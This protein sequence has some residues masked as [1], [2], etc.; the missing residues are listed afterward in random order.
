MV[1][2][3]SLALLATNSYCMYAYWN[4]DPD[5][6]GFFVIYNLQAYIFAR[7][8]NY[9]LLFDEDVS[10]RI[11]SPHRSFRP[12]YPNGSKPVAMNTGG[13]VGG[14]GGEERLMQELERQF[15]EDTAEFE[16][17]P[18]AATARGGGGGSGG[19]EAPRTLWKIVSK[20]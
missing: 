1:S 2:C 5:Y 14:L 17:S 11:N 12:F 4:W 18:S 8:V 7:C 19:S 3:R 10:T 15:R 9:D 20:A 13:G 6:F 16:K